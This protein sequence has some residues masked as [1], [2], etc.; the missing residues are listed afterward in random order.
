MS[1][2]LPIQI[3]FWLA[4]LTLLAVSAMTDL[5]ER[6]IRNQVVVAV[7]AIGV[8]LGLLTRPGALWLSLLAAASAFVALGVLSH[9][10]IIGGGDLK[11]ISAV[12]LLVP[13]DRIGQLLIDIALAGGVLGCVYLA[14]HYGL[15]GLSATPVGART[16][17]RSDTSDA[18]TIKAERN[19]ITALGPLPYG[20][21]ILFGVFA[22]ATGE[23]LPC[24]SARSCSL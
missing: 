21:A 1:I 9:Y 11:L 20:V 24:L 22:Y 23:F 6:L 13:P 8:T 12:T 19:R 2:L 15:K 17:A 3:A 16:L 10:Q 5:K 7:A 4:S 14:A 18:L